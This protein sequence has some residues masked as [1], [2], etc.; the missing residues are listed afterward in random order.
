MRQETHAGRTQIRRLKSEPRQERR[1]FWTKAPIVFTRATDSGLIPEIAEFGPLIERSGGCG[2]IFI[3]PDFLFLSAGTP[4][5]DPADV[6]RS[7]RLDTRW[8]ST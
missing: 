4:T 3:T 5:A 2:I 7:G 8:T 1:A 6:L